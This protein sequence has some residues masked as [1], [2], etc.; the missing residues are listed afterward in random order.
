M[1]PILGILDSA[2]T[3]NL[4]TGAFESIQ[5]ITV[6]SGGSSNITFT[7]IPNTYKTLQLRYFAFSD[8]TANN[9][10]DFNIR[11][12]NG[13]IDTSGNYT[14]LTVLGSGDGVGTAG[15]M[16]GYSATSIYSFICVGASS[17][18]K[19]KNG[20]GI[21]TFTD[22]ANTNKNKGIR[23][24]AGCDFNGTGSAG[25]PGRVGQTTGA[26]LNNSAIDQIRMYPQN[27]NWAQYSIFALYGIKGA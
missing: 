8:R 24:I 14:Y 21:V 3:G 11:V 20:I 26:W 1:T 16:S 7:S 25:A 27:S 23:V 5:T 9:L 6:G 4:V 15:T 10:D 2:K 13:S 22:Y 12:G 17:Q 18:A 19:E